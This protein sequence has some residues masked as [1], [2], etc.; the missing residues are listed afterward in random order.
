MSSSPLNN[1]RFATGG[2]AGTTGTS[3]SVPAPSAPKENP[4]GG[5][6]SSE[7]DDNL[8]ACWN[9]IGVYGKGDCPELQKFIHCRNCPVYSSAGLQLL[10][11]QLT[12]E[13]RREH[14]LHF[15]REKSVVVPGKMSAVIF[16][17]ANEWLSLPTQAF[18]EIAERRLVHSLPHRRKG[19]VLGLVNVRGELLICVSLGRLLGLEQI[20]PPDLARKTHDRLLVVSW[21]GNRLA[22]P[23][24]EV[25]GIH[26]FQPAELKAPP[27]TVAKSNPTSTLGIFAWCERAVGFLDADSLFASLNR[28]LT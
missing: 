10:N 14:T 15:A 5:S 3:S 17:I 2:L 16:R 4:A 18:L 7:A 25:H 8:Y 24:D 12:P 6:Q 13:Y 1:P 19:V 21:E 11:R 9:E 23:V 28:N 20:G 27:A 26:R 22:F